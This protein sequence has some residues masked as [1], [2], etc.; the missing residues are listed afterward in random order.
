MPRNPR[1]AYDWEGREF[2]PCG[3]MASG[4]LM[5]SAEIASAKRW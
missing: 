3:S 4:R 5:L 2:E 1:R